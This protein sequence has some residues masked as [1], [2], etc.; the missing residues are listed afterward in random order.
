M[1]IH[2]IALELVANALNFTDH[3]AVTLK[4]ELAKE[5]NRELIIKIS[6]IDTGIGIPREKQNIIFQQFKRLNPSYQGIYK[7]A[8]LGLSIIKQ[9]IDEI[10]AEI[11]VN[12]TPKEGSTFSC[13]IPVK[14]PLIENDEFI[15]NQFDSSDLTPDSGALPKPQ[16]IDKTCDK[17][18]IHNV[19]I[20]EDSIIAQ[21]IAKAML[22]Q[23]YCNVSIAETGIQAQEMWLKNQ[24]DLIFM[25]IGLPDIDG[26]EVTHFIRLKEASTKNHTPIVALTAHIGSESKKRCIDAGMNAVL[27]KP[28]TKDECIKVLDS[29]IPSRVNAMNN[30]QALYAKD[31]PN[32]DQELFNLTEFPILDIEQ[33]IET[34]GGE[35]M[36][37]QMIELMLN[38]TLENDLKELTDAHQNKDW[39]KVQKMAHKIKGGIVYV[40]AIKLK[41][42]CQYLERYYKAGNRKHL[43]KLYE[44][45]INVSN[46]TISEFKNHLNP[47]I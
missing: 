10:D 25:D 19:L 24:Y 27:S 34:T 4:V 9:F 46:E 6:V 18:N 31:L 3:G 14:K 16:F 21:S 17:K 30:E 26:Y 45:V 13:I 28:L 12:S 22:S 36:L 23:C 41:M 7:G 39:E 33:G 8:G 43:E 37:K 40:G 11:Y 32:D 5:E 29:F 42:A 47:E 38:K 2:R 44:Q 35:E 20:V 1:R 15:D